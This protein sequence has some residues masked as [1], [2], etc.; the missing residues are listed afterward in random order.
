[1]SQP[2]EA[3][4]W[5]DAEVQPDQE[6]LLMNVFGQLGVTARTRIVPPR[7]G[8]AKL[9]WLVLVALSLQALLGTRFADDACGGLKGLIGRLLPGAR[10]GPAGP[11][12]MVLRDVATGLEVVLEPDL[13]D[14]GYRQLLGL[15]LSSF[16]VGP[17]HSG[18]WHLT[19]R[20]APGHA[21]P[22]A[23]RLVVP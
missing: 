21:Y 12:P 5:L 11:R 16:Q 8:V 4:A 18:M 10:P 17:V 6:R 22:L 23:G 13:P 14:D 3:N 7:R 1:M 19:R 20:T 2:L 15:D 9:N